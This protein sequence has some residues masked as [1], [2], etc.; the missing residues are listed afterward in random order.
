MVLNPYSWEIIR[1]IAFIDEFVFCFWGKVVG[2]VITQLAVYFLFYHYT[3][4]R[5]SR[6]KHFDT[7]KKG[8]FQL[9]LSRV[10]QLENAKWQNDFGPVDPA[11]LVIS[12][13]FTQSCRKGSNLTCQ[14]ISFHNWTAPIHA[15]IVD[16]QKSCTSWY[17][18]MVNIP[19]FTGLYAS[20]VVQDLSH[21]PFPTIKIWS[22]RVSAHK[23]GPKTSSSSGGRDARLEAPWG[24]GKTSLHMGLGC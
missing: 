24:F 8:E 1:L 9:S 7:P 2:K 20:P 12:P 14:N 11:D 6:K 21:L 15:G 5:S 23:V 3:S 13:Y 10:L 17:G 4:T 22:F 16:E 19:L 18:K